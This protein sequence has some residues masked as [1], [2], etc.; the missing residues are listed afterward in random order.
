MIA[1]IISLEDNK[2]L[3]L[4]Q[5]KAFP[6]KTDW[7]SIAI[8]QKFYQQYLNVWYSAQLYPNPCLH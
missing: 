8:Y 2:R 7:Y 4:N 3:A 1:S 6:V 5:S